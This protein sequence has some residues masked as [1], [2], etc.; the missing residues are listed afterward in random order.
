[1]SRRVLTIIVL[2]FGVAVAAS[3]S[4]WASNL[5]GGYGTTHSASA[6]T[7]NGVVAVTAGVHRHPISS[8]SPTT[9]TDPPAGSGAPAPDPVTCTIVPVNLLAFQE[10]LGPGPNGET[11]YW[12]LDECTGPDGRIPEPPVFIPT[13][14]PTPAG[15]APAPPPPPAAVALQAEKQVPLASPTI[16]TAPPLNSEQLVNVA[17]WLWID[18]ASWKPLQASATIDGVSASATATPEKVVWSTGDGSTLTCDGPGTPYD[19][20]DPGATSDC[21]YT[22]TTSSADEPNG[23]FTLT[24]TI[25]W[26]VTWVAVGA[27]GGGDLGFVA[28]PPSEAQV[29]VAT[30]EALNTNGSASPSG[31]S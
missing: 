28:G 24:A 12:A 22:W 21:T 20:A 14:Q 13:N 10:I 30:S 26:Q 11:G 29:R 27:P 6:S 16:D 7:H 5:S 9:T 4:A 1:M 3:S 25:Y 17:A 23:A 2:A 8:A 18:P 19:A 31:G 15:A